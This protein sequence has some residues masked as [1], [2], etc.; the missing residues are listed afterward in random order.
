[1]DGSTPYNVQLFAV[2]NLVVSL[3]MV[4]LIIKNNTDQAEKFNFVLLYLFVSQYEGVAEVCKWAQVW[5][6]SMHSKYLYLQMTTVLC[7]L[8][9]E[10]VAS[11]CRENSFLPL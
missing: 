7:S 6:I 8:Y 2:S 10:L 11:H 4:S 3:Y 9:L 1:M 5:G